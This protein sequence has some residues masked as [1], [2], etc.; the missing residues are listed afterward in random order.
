MSR[1]ARLS[2]GRRRILVRSIDAA[3]RARSIVT[4][5]AGRRDRKLPAVMTEPTPADIARFEALAP[6]Q[7][8]AVEEASELLK[9][10]IA[11][12]Q[13]LREPPADLP[14]AEVDLLRR[15]HVAMSD[16]LSFLVARI[17]LWV[18]GFGPAAAPA[19]APAPGLDLDSDTPLAPAC[20]LSG[21]NG[22]EACQ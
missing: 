22:C 3:L 13:F 2:S 14:K 16:Y 20:D 8:R 7:Q 10:W 15:Q 21:E 19:P 1:P 6:H 5:P 17:Q 9:R 12:E 4:A 11:L 18:P